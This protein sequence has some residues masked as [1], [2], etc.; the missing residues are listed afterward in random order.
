M[1]YKVEIQEV[2]TNKPVR[3][4][5]KLLIQCHPKSLE[6]EIKK[7]VGLR[8]VILS[9]K[10]APV[11]VYHVKYTTYPVFD[12]I[13]AVLAYQ[14][15]EKLTKSE[16]AEKI[17]ITRPTLDALLNKQIYSRKTRKK[18]EEELGVSLDGNY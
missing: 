13:Q 18:I 7:E 3:Y 15:V 2:E 9:D 1:I 11:E 6:K 16:L 10:W 17:G 8:S 4:P 5:L 14:E 12:I